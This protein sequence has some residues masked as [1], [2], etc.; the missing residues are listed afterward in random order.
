MVYEKRFYRQWVEA[1]GLVQF[2]VDNGE[3]DLLILAARN[4]AWK[5]QSVLAEARSELRDYISRDARFLTSLTPLRVPPAAPRLVRQMAGAAQC[6][7]VG[8]MAAVAGAV[9]EVVGERLLEESPHVIVEN[10]GDI[11]MK[12]EGRRA[13]ALYAGEDSPF[14]GKLRIF[15]EPDGAPLGICTSSATV[16]HSL[17]FGKADAVV[18]VAGSAALA[19]AAATAICNRI[20]QPADIRPALERERRRGLL[21]GLLISLGRHL[22]VWGCVELG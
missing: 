4:L 7:E 19:D 6:Y 17:S 16:G 9:A 21:K 12:A 3:S 13:V 20:E 18:A 22:G 5:A 15:V 10:G 11:F 2:E 1:G 8:P 14:S